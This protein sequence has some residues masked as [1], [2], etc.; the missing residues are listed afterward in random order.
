[1][2]HKIIICKRCGCNLRL[3]ANKGILAVTCPKCKYK[4]QFD[5]GPKMSST[6]GAAQYKNSTYETVQTT[7]R[8]VTIFRLTHAHKEWDAS[9]L[10]NMLKDNMPVHIFADDQDQGTLSKDGSLTVTLNSGP[11]TLKCAKLGTKYVIPAGADGYEAYFF[12]NSLRIGPVQDYF[13]ERLTMFVLKM[14]RSQGMRDRMNDLNNRHHNIVVNVRAD[15]IYLSWQLAQTKGIKQWATGGDEEKISYYQA[16]LTPLPQ[17]KQP[18]GYW[19]YIQMRI[20][21][22]IEADEEADMERYMGGFRMR[23]KHKLY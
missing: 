2:E 17:E 10:G 1:M 13:R 18:G 12:N 5:S 6:G 22:A 8:T 9:G 3:P 14:F 19:D 11:H 23:T 4:F 7:S 16:G 15:G 21:D 20:E